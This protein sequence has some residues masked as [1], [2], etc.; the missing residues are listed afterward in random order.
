MLGY[1]DIYLCLFHNKATAVRHLVR[2]EF[3]TN[4]LRKAILLTIALR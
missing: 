2:I 3:S 1:V 4:D